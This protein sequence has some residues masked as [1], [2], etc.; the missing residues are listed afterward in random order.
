MVV[1]NEY[2][3][4]PNPKKA[5]RWHSV[6]DLGA[7][8]RNLMFVAGPVGSGHGPARVTGFSGMESLTKTHRYDHEGTK[9]GMA[10]LFQID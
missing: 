4:S 1:E 3:G 8:K 2:E 5:A 6:R 7:T 10:T 9:Y